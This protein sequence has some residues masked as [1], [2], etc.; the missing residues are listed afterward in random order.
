MIIERPESCGGGKFKNLQN[1]QSKKFT[2][3]CPCLPVFHT[4]YCQLHGGLTL[5]YFAK[6]LFNSL[7]KYHSKAG[8]M[9]FSLIFKATLFVATHNLSAVAS[10]KL[11]AHTQSVST[12]A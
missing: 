3:L 6:M 1:A 8:Q 10:I 5:K 4:S 7:L 2:H 12:A 9:T 11:S